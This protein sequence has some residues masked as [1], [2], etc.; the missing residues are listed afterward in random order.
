MISYAIL[1]APPQA[2]GSGPDASLPVL[3]AL[4]GAGLE[5]DDQLVRHALDDL[6]DL[7]A[8]TMLPTGVTP[9]SGDDWHIWGWED[10]E[11]GIA[12]IPDW[13]QQVDWQG[14][15]VDT[16]RLLVA[17]HSNGGQGT[18]NALTHH[19]DKIVAAAPLSGYSAIQHY[20]PYTFWRTA[21][22]G[23]TAVVHAAMNSYQ[24]D[25]LLENPKGIPV[26]EQHGSA[27]DNVPVYHSRLMNQRV[28]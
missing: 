22:P 25:L 16:N 23:R 4:H 21:D 13:I 18:W 7:C 3:L 5:A 15:G 27:D 26:L 17:G 19:F 1:R 6:P 14:P 24:H 12:M 28:Q 10:V 11:A 2:C 9:W 8:W 20:V